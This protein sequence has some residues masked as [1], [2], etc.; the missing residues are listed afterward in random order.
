MNRE[1]HT[2]RYFELEIGSHRSK[3]PVDD[4]RTCNIGAPCRGSSVWHSVFDIYGRRI[5]VRCPGG[6]SD[7]E[8]EGL[9][10]PSVVATPFAVEGW[11][12]LLHTAPSLWPTGVVAVQ[13]HTSAP[14]LAPGEELAALAGAQLAK[15]KRR[16]KAEEEGEEEAP[17]LAGL[18]DPDP[19]D[20]SPFDPDPSEE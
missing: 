13:W 3:V 19:F 20:P 16:E 12:G 5:G 6:L 11:V 9:Q 10:N 15:E 18:F 17:D 8:R 14:V 4:E 2:F 1:I 7:D